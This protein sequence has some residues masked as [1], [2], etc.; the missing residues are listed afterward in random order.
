MGIAEDYRHAKEI[1]AES[2]V[3]TDRAIDMLN[4]IPI[5]VNCW[6]LDDLSGFEA[7][8]RGLSGGIAAF[9]S[10]PGKPKN[11][12]EYIQN[13][14]SALKL[15]PGC[16][17][18]ALH[19]IYPDAGCERKGRDQL[20]PS[21]LP[22]GLISPKNIE[23]AWTSTQLTSAIQWRTADSLCPVRTAVYA[24]IGLSTVYGAVK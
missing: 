16:T 11:R 17:K 13:L 6:Q 19:A 9:G 8:E 5:S 20:E 21:D 1:Y 3:D 10:A 15:I 7:P 22:V 12:E 24:I 23:S 2:G 18:L 14:E 4:K